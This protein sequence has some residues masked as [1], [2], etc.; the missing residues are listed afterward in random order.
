MNT[1][2]MLLLQPTPQRP[3]SAGLQRE[4]KIDDCPSKNEPPGC[5]IERWAAR[6]PRRRPTR[7]LLLLQIRVS[8]L[9][10]ARGP[11]SSAARAGSDPHSPSQRI[12]PEAKRAEWRS[13]PTETSRLY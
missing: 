9:R 13:A 5:Q 6:M 10:A 7:M 1:R 8:S 12:R 4:E 3:T 11:S 2:E